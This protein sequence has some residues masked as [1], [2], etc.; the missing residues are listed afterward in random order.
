VPNQ[1]YPSKKALA[2][3]LIQAFVS[4][5]TDIEIK[6]TIGDAFYNTKDFFDAVSR[7]TKQPKIISQIKSTQLINV[8]GQFKQVGE[9][10]A[11]FQGKT[12]IVQLRSKDKLI[13]FSSAKFKVKSH[14]KKLYLIVL[15]YGD[16][17][18]YRYLIANDTTWRNIEVIK[19]M[20][21][22]GL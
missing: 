16:E 5:F 17:S 13:T 20:D 3:K 15:K 14:D 19:V 4:N 9:F 8:G 2:L 11:N 21:S 7:T 12:E 1:Q 6:A 22:V 10:F 18:E